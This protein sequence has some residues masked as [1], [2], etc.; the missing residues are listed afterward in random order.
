[1]SKRVLIFFAVGILAIVVGIFLM[2]YE[3][4]KKDT[5]EEP[6]EEPEE[7]LEEEP[8]PVPE[9]VNDRT[10][11]YYDRSKRAWLKCKEKEVPAE[12]PVE[13]PNVIPA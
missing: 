10:G 11:Y 4:T 6:E 1:M 2:R 13:E 9:V 12:V 5:E 3:L 7:D 8:E